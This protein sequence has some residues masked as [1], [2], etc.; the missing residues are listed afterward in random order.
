MAE[1][2]SS[3]IECL[4]SLGLVGL[5]AYIFALIVGIKRSFSYLKKSHNVAFAF[6]GAFL[7]FCATDGLAE[8]AVL[9]SP[10]L[11]FLTMAVLIE[12]GFRRIDLLSGGS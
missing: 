7:I 5:A 11:S 6:S 3:Y 2:H 12:L 10:T 8:S 9:L 4:L 1:A